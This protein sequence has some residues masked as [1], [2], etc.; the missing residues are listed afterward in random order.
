MLAPGY[1]LSH[2]P[3]DLQLEVIHGYLS[4]SYW[5]PG[6]PRHL[7]AKAIEHSLTVGAFAPSGAQVG[8]ARMV[9]DHVSFGYLSDVFVL[10]QHRGKGLGHA[11]TRALLELPEV[12][13]FRTLLLA[14]RDAHGLYADCGF[15]RIE[16]PARFMQ[17]RRPGNYP[18]PA[19]AG[20]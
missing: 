16:D 19:P 9:T 4:R 14:T 5:S 8:F 10:E 7:V 13:G 6:I 3:A 17:I 20:A 15:E 1:R 11:L 2:D 12:R 18:G